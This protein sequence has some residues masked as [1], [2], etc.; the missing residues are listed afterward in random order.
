[1]DWLKQRAIEALSGSK[2]ISRRLL[3]LI[4]AIVVGTVLL[5]N[6]F[7]QKTDA[8]MS[9][10]I[11]TSADS[12]TSTE[13]SLA[14]NSASFYV[15]VVG[16]VAN[17]GIYELDAGSRIVDAI[18][19]A[20]GFLESADQSSINLAREIS[21]GEQV[22]VFKVGEAPQFSSGGTSEGALISLNRA[23]QQQLESLP[24]VG[25]ALATRIIDWRNANGGFKKKEDLLNISGIGDKL[26]AGIKNQVTL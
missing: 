23:N 13:T 26:F 3:F 22:V 8:S 20:G 18:F 15:H 25:P 24:G 5:I 4:G 9:G 2:P 1:M 12:P 21:D 11:E 7:A 14:I 10:Q 17:P 6:L 19:A 16:E